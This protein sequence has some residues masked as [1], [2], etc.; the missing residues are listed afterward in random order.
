MGV[1][2]DFQDD[3]F[4]FSNPELEFSISFCKRLCR[5]QA[6]VELAALATVIN[7]NKITSHLAAAVQVSR[8]HLY[9]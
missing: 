8:Y 4:I 3:V 7:R 5:Q 6:T 9:S 2:L 1:N